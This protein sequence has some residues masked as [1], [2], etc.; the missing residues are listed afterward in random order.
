MQ[1]NRVVVYHPRF[2]AALRNTLAEA[3]ADL[4]EMHYRHLC[5]LADLKKEIAELRAIFRDVVTMLRQQSEADVARLRRQLETALVKLA[6]RDPQKP[7][8]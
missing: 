1:H 2:I 4:H 5:E 8:H 6:Q 3:K 7:L